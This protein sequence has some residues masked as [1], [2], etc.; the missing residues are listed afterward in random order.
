MF[1]PYPFRP[2]WQPNSR[3][4]LPVFTELERITQKLNTAEKKV[5]EYARL[6]G[7]YAIL[8]SKSAYP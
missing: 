7:F 8:S 5:D 1:V 2:F 6:G 3:T 4:S